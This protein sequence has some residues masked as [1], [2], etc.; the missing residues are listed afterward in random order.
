MSELL[1]VRLVMPGR[2]IA[3]AESGAAYDVVLD[4]AGGAVGVGVTLAVVGFLVLRAA[5][6]R[7]GSLYRS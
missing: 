7:R 3:G 5:I 2:V 6:S 1:Q 4:W